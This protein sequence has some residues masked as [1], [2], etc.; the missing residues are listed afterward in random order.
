[1]AKTKTNKSKSIN[2]LFDKYS[3]LIHTGT[4]ILQ[5]RQNFKTI[6]V[7]PAIDIA[8]GGGIREGSWLTLT[9]DPKSGKT[10]TA[11][12]IGANCQKEGRPIIYL[13][14]E[15]RLKEMNF[16]VP[17][18][19]PEKM[20]VVAPEN[21]PISAEEFLKIA[22]EMMT[23]KD[24]EGAVLI[25]DSISSLM[26]EKELDGDFSPG[27]AGLP[28]ILSI[29][30]KKIGQLLPR[31]KGLVIAITHYIA[32]TAGFGKAKMSDG[33][34][35]I[36]YQADTR[37]EI[38]GGG[39]KVS[40]VSPWMNA[41][42]TERI[43]QVVNWRIICSSLGAPGGQVQSYIRYGHGI[44]KVQELLMLSCDLGLIEPRGS[45]FSMP[46]MNTCKDLAKEI[47]P[48]LNTDNDEALASAFKFQGQEKTY[49]FLKENPKV[50]DFLESSIKEM[51]K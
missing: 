48:E 21:E 42:K 8:L 23:H 22:Y 45:W 51:L 46:F 40:A 18:L 10:T 14:V 6:S 16:E 25:I 2:Q 29:F 9:G 15:G 41:A 7:S 32:N 47:K 11:M 13:D 31:Q 49:N 39:E 30:T 3:D 1:M 28:K 27:R 20:A 33:G 44:D 24:Y 26:P 19:D 36:Q 5:Q 17:D 12:Q 4:E 34:N 38:A 43:G 37:M 35:K 50:I